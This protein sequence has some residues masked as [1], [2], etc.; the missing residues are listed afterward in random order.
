MN[1]VWTTKCWNQEIS[2]LKFAITWYSVNNFDNHVWLNV[3]PKCI[4][5]CCLSSKS[6][7]ASLIATATKS[8]KK[9]TEHKQNTLSSALIWLFS[10]AFI[11]S[12][13][14]QKLVTSCNS[15]TSV[16]QVK[17]VFP[18][19]PLF[20]LLPEMTNWGKCG[21]KACNYTS[22]LL[23]LTY[24]QKELLLIKCIFSLVK[25]FQNRNQ[26]YYHH[27]LSRPHKF[28]GGMNHKN[29]SSRLCLLRQRLD[30]FKMK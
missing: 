26:K 17:S 27:F 5:N 13:L 10:K 23:T 22:C 6:K 14:L 18:I 20:P 12:M 28:N 19:S 2:R 3:G 15:F 11:L 4:I 16:L 24:F 25:C 1:K 8:C 21:K 7:Q 30:S 29:N 9:F